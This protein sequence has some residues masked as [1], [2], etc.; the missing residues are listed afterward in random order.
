MT[1]RM[2]TYIIQKDI[3]LKEI[4][5]LSPKDL[6]KY[7]HIPEKKAIPLYQDLHNSDLIDQIKQDKKLYSIISIFDQAYP[8]S[9]KT[10]KDPPLVLY[11]LGN[12]NLLSRVPSISVI[13]T[14]KPTVE[15][16]KKTKLIVQPLVEKGWV[17]VSGMARGIDTYAHQEALAY[18]GNTIAVL[19]SGFNHIYPKE[20]HALFTEISKSGIVLSEYPPGAAA[21]RFHFPE[22]NR[23]ISGLTFGT[24][25]IEA[26]EKSGTLITVDQA[27]DQGREVYAIPGSPLVAQ[28]KGCHRMIQEGAKL[29]IDAQCIFEDWDTQGS[30]F[31]SISRD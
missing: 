1:R 14:R 10:I 24:L 31:A 3:E 6:T 8:T 28:T 27:L 19:G 15:A 20:N 13:G 17:I 26:T 18:N 21:S 25:V 30:Y 7:F 2:L 9:L 16:R 22:R 12:L 29:V 4:Y 23:I 11:T 5:Y